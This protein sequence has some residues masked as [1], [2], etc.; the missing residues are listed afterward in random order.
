MRIILILLILCSCVVA[1]AAGIRTTNGYFCPYHKDTEV[2]QISSK[3]EGITVCIRCL[4][5]LLED[6]LPKTYKVEK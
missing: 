4:M 1:E 5:V 2:V 6:N 3:G